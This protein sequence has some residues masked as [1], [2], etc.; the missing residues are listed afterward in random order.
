M[1]TMAV[2][3]PP[4]LL[5]VTVKYVEEVMEVGV[6]LMAPVVLE[7][8]RPAGNDGE[9]DHELTAPPLEVG[10]TADMV[11]SLVSESELGL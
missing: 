8:D 11:T 10:V 2:A 4:V 3:L 9:I 5:A 6:P 7:N 1:V